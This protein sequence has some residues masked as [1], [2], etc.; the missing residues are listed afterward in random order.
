M[1]SNHRGIPRRSP[2]RL[3]FFR[4]LS[5]AI[6]ADVFSTL[7][8][9]TPEGWDAEVLANGFRE[10]VIGWIHEGVEEGL[11]IFQAVGDLEAVE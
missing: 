1:D 10:W 3:Q 2:E 8:E 7:V 9:R 5:A 4:A 6:G 11:T